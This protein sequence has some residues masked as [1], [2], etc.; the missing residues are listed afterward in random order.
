MIESGRPHKTKATDTH[1]GYVIILL[2]WTTTVRRARHN[3]TL[4][5]HYLSCCII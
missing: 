2:F 1:S 3:I 4:Y 5:V